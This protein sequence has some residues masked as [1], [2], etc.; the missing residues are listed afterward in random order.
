MKASRRTTFAAAAIAAMLWQTRRKVFSKFEIWL[1]FERTV[2]HDKKINKWQ[3]SSQSEFMMDDLRNLN[4]TIWAY[5]TFLN[6]YIKLRNTSPMTKPPAKKGHLISSWGANLINWQDQRREKEKKKRRERKE[7]REVR[8]LL[9]AMFPPIL[10]LTVKLV[11]EESG[12][13]L[14]LVEFWQSSLPSIIQPE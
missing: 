2:V 3:N 14:L 4:L 10:H 6:T 7:K 11:G 5:T 1:A 8:D 13:I 12:S 9:M